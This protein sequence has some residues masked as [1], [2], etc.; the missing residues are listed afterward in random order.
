MQMV[1]AFERARAE[2]VSY[3]DRKES[4]KKGGCRWEVGMGYSGESPQRENVT[5]L[6][7]MEPEPP[8]KRRQPSLIVTGLKELQEEGE[9]ESEPL[10]SLP[11]VVTKWLYYT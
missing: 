6:R 7:G 2:H 4:L 1:V 5:T 9:K 8:R 3:A 11:H 10:L